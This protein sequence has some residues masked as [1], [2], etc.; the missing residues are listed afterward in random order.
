M[1]SSPIFMSLGI[2]M[3][4]EEQEDVEAVSWTR[5]SLVLMLRMP[6][7]IEAVTVLVPI[8]H[9]L[10]MGNQKNLNSSEQI[11]SS[12]DS[13]MPMDAIVTMKGFFSLHLVHFRIKWWKETVLDNN[14]VREL[15]QTRFLTGPWQ[16]NEPFSTAID[17]HCKVFICFTTPYMLSWH[18]VEDASSSPADGKS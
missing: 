5:K 1:F 6:Y 18:L 10:G 16:S 15:W 8:F 9:L 13:L 14:S 4:W 7:P 2:C 3:L 11:I 17:L 12:R